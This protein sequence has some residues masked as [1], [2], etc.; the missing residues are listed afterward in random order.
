MEFDDLKKNLTEKELSE[1][2]EDFE[3]YKE[4]RKKLLQ[5]RKKD[6]VNK[7]DLYSSIQKALENITKD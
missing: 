3:K 4:T 6:R 2:I 1:F 5:Q 7:S